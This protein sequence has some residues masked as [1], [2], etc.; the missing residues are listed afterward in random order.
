MIPEAD[1][2]RMDIFSA[3]LNQRVIH[4]TGEIDDEMSTSV[5]A[6]L[7]YF[8]SPDLNS[9]EYQ[10]VQIYINSPG[11][12]VSAGLAIYDTMQF[13]RNEVIT[14][15]IG[16]AA[17]MAAI[18]L[19]GGTKGS[20][21]ILPH[22]EVMIHQPSGGMEGQSSDMVIAADHIRETREILNKI[23]AENT[24]KKEEDI[25]KDTERDFWMKAREAVAYGLADKIL[26]KEDTL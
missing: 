1:R 16:R 23:L 15:C 13:I 5:I 10:P 25:V 24:G 7:L 3:N 19:S 8:N 17:S 18:L 9:G 6:Q 12:S 14:V 11:G 22:S 4:L 2:T 20:R 26:K 21:F